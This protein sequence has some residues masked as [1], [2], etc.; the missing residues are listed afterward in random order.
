MA[1]GIS[2]G[3]AFGQ[4]ARIRGATARIA[5]RTGWS[6]V[7][8]RVVLSVWK[9]RDGYCKAVLR[10]EHRYDLNGEV[11]EEIVDDRAREQAQQKLAARAAR[12]LAP[13]GPAEKAAQR[14]PTH[15]EI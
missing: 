7:Y 4:T 14:M 10:Y 6:N 1:R 8:A 11:T 5:E 2:E 9:A 12:L 3:V 13:P 15:S